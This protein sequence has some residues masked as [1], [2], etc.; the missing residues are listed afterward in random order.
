MVR[1]RVLLVNPWIYDFAAYDYGIKPVGLLRI[2]SHLRLKCD[3]FLIDCLSGCARSKQE[4]GFSKI[5]KERIEKPQIVK[6]IQRPY[7]RYGIS[8]DGL[9]AKLAR[10]IEPNAIYVTSGMTYWYPGVQ[11]T[12]RIVREV[13]PKVPITLGG[14]YATLCPEHAYNASGADHIWSGEYMEDEKEI[15]FPA[16]DLLE[17]KT[18]LPMAY[19][20]NFLHIFGNKVTRH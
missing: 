2:A 19:I 7:F 13:F 9:K 15:D 4:S 1:K 14:I 8:P 11:Q 18:I 10:L 6:G 17:D 12:I 5:R 20:I 3:V 16:Y